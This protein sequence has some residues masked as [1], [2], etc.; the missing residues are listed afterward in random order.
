[1]KEEEKTKCKVFN[2]TQKIAL[3]EKQIE[4]VKEIKMLETIPTTNLKWNKYTK[5]LVKRAYARWKS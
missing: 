4:M 3:N 5:H 2:F 1:M